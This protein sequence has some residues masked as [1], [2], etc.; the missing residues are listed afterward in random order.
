MTGMELSVVVPIYNERDDL[1][2]LQDADGYMASG[3]GK[4]SRV[5]LA[6][7]ADVCSKIGGEAV[8]LVHPQVRGSSQVERIVAEQFTILFRTSRRR[9][10]WPCAC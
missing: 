6:M 7:V 9:S 4:E 5:D 8:Q 10:I 3:W 1:H 2:R